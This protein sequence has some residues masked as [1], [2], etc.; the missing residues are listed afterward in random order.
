M[1]RTS[2]AFGGF[3]LIELL[4]ALAVVIIVLVLI[5]QLTTITADVTQ[6][7]Q[8]RMN[9]GA[10]L[11]GAFDRL[12]ADFAAAVVRRDLPPFLEK[13]AGNDACYFY[14]TTTGYGGERGVT[15]VGYRIQDGGLAR[16]AEGTGWAD[17]GPAFSE[18][19]SAS[20]F[21]SEADNTNYE[22][23]AERIFR[24]ELEFLMTD[25]TVRNSG[26]LTSWNDVHSV[27]VTMA[28]IDEQALNRS[29]GNLSD[30]VALFPDPSGNERVAATWSA[31][32][33]NPAFFGGNPNFPPAS[34][35][36][37]DIRQRTFPVRR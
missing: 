12:A 30:L 4:V 31:L 32:L 14:A 34:L 37:I 26:T 10:G 18:P 23:L 24:M 28:A 2:R 21:V 13:T 5:L 29:N 19:L 36:T 16:G 7:S 20:P 33:N 17:E 15:R 11:R 9:R 27:I 6:S 3:T 8:G 1:Q 35:Q 25:G 22:V